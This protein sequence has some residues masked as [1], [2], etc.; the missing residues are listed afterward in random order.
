LVQG[1]DEEVS[2]SYI[3]SDPTQD[4]FS[5]TLTLTSSTPTATGIVLA[6]CNGLDFNP[7][8]DVTVT[9]NVI[10]NEESGFVEIHVVTTVTNNGDVA[11]V[12]VVVTDQGT[13][14]P[15]DDE[16]HN[17]PE[18][19]VDS[20]VSYDRTIQA[21]ELPEEFLNASTSCGGVKRFIEKRRT[22]NTDKTESTKST[23]ADKT[24]STKST[25]ADKTESDHSEADK[26]ES[27]HSEADK[28]ESDHSEADKTEDD[29]EESST[30]GPITITYSYTVGAT[31]TGTSKVRG[32][33]DASDSASSSCSSTITF[34]G[35]GVTDI[36]E[37][38][39]E[40]DKTESD[41]V[42]VDHTESDKVE[43]DHTESDKAEEDHTESDK[44]EEDHTESDNVEEDHTEYD[45]TEGDKVEVDHTESDKVEEEPEY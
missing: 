24:E 12:N 18:L 31:A 16:V 3:P 25:T 20:S 39:H 19:D 10:I 36:P 23:T 13:S 37:D 45:H 34:C 43:E 6:T 9:C 33:G 15:I 8:I 1:A 22:R 17:I 32:F 14:D 41:K 28:T 7:S 29:H 11:L 38:D 35:E 27:D 30:S 4:T 26:T 42:E 5:D 21:D 40:S 2:G 44:V